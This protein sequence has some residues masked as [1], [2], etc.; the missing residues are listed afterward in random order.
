PAPPPPRPAPPSATAP[1]PIAAAP[2]PAAAPPAAPAFVP[3]PAPRPA[4]ARSTDVPG[5][6]E[7]ET[8]ALYAK[9][10]KAR[11]VVGDKSEGFSYDKLVRTLQSQAPKILEQ[12]KAQK[13]EFN[14]VIRDNKVILK[15]KPK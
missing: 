8:R 14:V 9:F 11:E 10:V 5:M 12:H 1:P 3:R 7:A 4:V 6:T 13:V 15:A 2:P